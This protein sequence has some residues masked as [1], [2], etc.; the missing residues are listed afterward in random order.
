[1]GVL[2][3]DRGTGAQYL[4]YFLSS[5]P[6]STAQVGKS[7]SDIFQPPLQVWYRVSFRFSQSE[8]LKLDLEDESE[9]GAMLLLLLLF[10][11]AIT[12]GYYYF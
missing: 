9:V 8:T 4:F 7:N 2:A 10:L 6:S 1:M 3:T 12:G 5:M 11:L